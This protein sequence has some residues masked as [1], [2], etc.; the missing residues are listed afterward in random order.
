[1][2]K[3][4]TRL[5]KLVEKLEARI[6]KRFDQRIPSSINLKKRYAGPAVLPLAA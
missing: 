4:D 5:E 1:M 2:E 3:Q 6:D